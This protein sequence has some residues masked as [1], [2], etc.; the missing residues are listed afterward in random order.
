MSN[1]ISSF[2]IEPV[3]RQA[4]RFS[5]LSAGSEPRHSFANSLQ[6][7]HAS[8]LGNVSP[9]RSIGEDGDVFLESGRMN[10]DVRIGPLQ[11]T[12]DQRHL[13]SPPPDP[14]DLSL[15]SQASGHSDGQ[16][17]VWT[18][19]VSEIPVQPSAA[20]S[21]SR[22]RR[23]TL[24]T[25]NDTS[26]NPSYGIPR[27]FRSSDQLF[28][29]SSQVATDGS[30]ASTDNVAQGDAGGGHDAVEA[31]NRNIKS[32]GFLPEDDGMGFLRKRIHDIRD[33]PMSS[34][35]KARLIHGLMTENYSSSQISLHSIPP[36]RPHSPASL[37]SQDRPFTPSSA[38]SARMVDRRAVSPVSTNSASAVDLRKRYNLTPDDLIP[39]YA[40]KP[41]PYP[42][43]DVDETS[44]DSRDEE[45]SDEEE[46]Q[47]G[48]QHYKRNVKLQCFA[49]KRWY[50]CRF[51]HDE[52]E[53]HLLNRQETENM[54]CML[55]GCPQSAGEWCK[56]CGERA[57]WYYCSV[58]KLWDNDT[59]KNIYHCS[60]CGICRV[61]QGLGKDYFHCKVCIY[62]S[63]PERLLT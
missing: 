17:H 51:C 15:S 28:T 61:G 63:L 39:T 46:D 45:M 33:R 9:P 7:E 58:C 38:N 10:S 16:A 48:C 32:S 31:Y 37:M 50:T 21:A 29:L 4:R 57:A 6:D 19:Q 40:T 42:T 14:T 36:P 22:S 5:R 24:R 1:Y 8:T 56:D 26:I 44:R 3:V 53:D 25:D 12:F 18:F 49:C 13:P 60:D 23:R 20:P 43:S 59:E 47:L 35:E 30:S 2:F 27:R 52:V 54:L 62:E 34:V 11:T 41:P 55:C